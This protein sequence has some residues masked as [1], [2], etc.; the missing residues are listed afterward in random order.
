MGFTR[1]YYLACRKILN[2]FLKGEHNMFG[3][4]KKLFGGD[5]SLNKEVGVQIEQVSAPYKVE[6]VAPVAEKAVAAVVKS[7]AKPAPKKKY[8]SK[9][10]PAAKTASTPKSAAKKPKAKPAV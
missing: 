4:I 5:A 8:Y 6:T 10:K 3:F 1:F 2:I 9:K 7:I